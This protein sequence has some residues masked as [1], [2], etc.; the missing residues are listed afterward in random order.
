LRRPDDGATKAALQFSAMLQTATP[1]P[2]R[3]KIQLYLA[4]AYGLDVFEVFS[5][6]SKPSI[7][8]SDCGF[9]IY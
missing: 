1:L 5:A 8:N 6:H 4:F 7:E 3:V 9:A 2:S